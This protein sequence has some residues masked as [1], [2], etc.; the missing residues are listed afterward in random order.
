MR[1]EAL[2]YGLIRLSDGSVFTFL[3]ICCIAG[4]RAIPESQIRRPADYCFLAFLVIG[5]ARHEAD[6]SFN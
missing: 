2:F 6:E 3:L 1:I 5:Y 4:L